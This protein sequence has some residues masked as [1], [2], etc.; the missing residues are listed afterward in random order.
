MNCSWGLTEILSDDMV[1]VAMCMDVRKGYVAKDLVKK[2]K[3]SEEKIQKCLDEMADI[4]GAW[5]AC[6][7]IF[8]L[9]SLCRCQSLFLEMWKA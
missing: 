5:E 6:H 4:D 2:T 7:S 8:G 3:M 9:V 1:D